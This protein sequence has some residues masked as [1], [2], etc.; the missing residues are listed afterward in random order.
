MSW[1][2]K[3]PLAAFLQPADKN[4]ELGVETTKSPES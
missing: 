4:K 3:K 2:E 1:P